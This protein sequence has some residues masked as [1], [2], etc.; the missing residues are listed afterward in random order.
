VTDSLVDG[1]RDARD[2]PAVQVPALLRNMVRVE[3]KAGDQLPTE[4]ELS[5]RFAVSRSTIREAMKLL[6]QDGLVYAIQ[7]RGRF[8]SALGSFSVERP[9]TRYESMTDMLESLGY[10][11]TTIVLDVREIGAPQRVAALLDIPVGE[12]VIQLTRLR[13]D[14]DT[15]LVFNVNM[16]LRECLPGPIAYRDW[17]TSITAALE[18]HGHHIESSAARI[19][20]VNL[21]SEDAKRYGL[22]DL[23]PW[24]AVE[25]T[26]ITRDGLRV[27]YALDY[28]RGDVLAF[29]VL[30]RR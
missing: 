5:A 17:A 14:G 29:N 21:P 28:H 2:S 20:A 3:L 7:G 9:I 27:M 1:V 13:L 10:R 12:P 30:R 8:V 11:V 23:D 26:C 19:S 6:E 4:T 18:A 24:L 15:P 16:V 25:E 22:G